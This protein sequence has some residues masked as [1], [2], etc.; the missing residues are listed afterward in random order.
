MTTT[1]MKVRAV[2]IAA[3][4]LALAGVAGAQDFSSPQRIDTT[5]SLERG[6]TVSVSVYSGRVTVVGGQGSNVRIRGRVERGELQLSART[7]SVNISTEPEGPH[8]GNAEF[9]ITVPIGTRVVLEGFSAPLSVRGVKGAAKVESL[10]GGIQVADAAGQV[11]VSTVSGN[12]A[13]SKVDGDVRADA[14]SGRLDITD[15]DGNIDG[16]SVSGGVAIVGARSKSV[17]A[18]TVSGS[19]GYSG[20]FDPAGNYTFKTHAGRIR[21]G[22]PADAGATVSLQTFS[23]N[24]DSDFPVTLES[25]RQRMGHESKFEFR[26]GNGRSR[27]VA[28]TFSGDIRIQRGTDRD[29]REP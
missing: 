1:G 20:T 4:M 15:V 12:I 16:E 13:V 23:G 27:I 17:R 3:A 19:V 2:S 7:G 9:D 11:I 14:V 25:G 6:G 5:V 18:E 8:G 10:S 24:V 29:N 22:M 21:L 28:E 26:I